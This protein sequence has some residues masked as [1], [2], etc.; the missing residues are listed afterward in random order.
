MIRF[1]FFLFVACATFNS[2]A[3][4]LGKSGDVT[5]LVKD[6]FGTRIPNAE[7]QFARLPSFKTDEEGKAIIQNVE[8]GRSYQIKVSAKDYR[9]YDGFHEIDKK[10]STITIELGWTVERWKE[11]TEQAR[12]EEIQSRDSI[13]AATDF[14]EYADCDDTTGLHYWMEAKFPGGQA[15]LNQY[16]DDMT[17]YPEPSIDMNEQGKVYLSFVVEMDG[18]ITG[19]KIERGVSS[20]IDREARRI[21]RSMPKWI[22]AYCNGEKV[23]VRCRVPIVFTLT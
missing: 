21:V 13:V 2:Q 20:D 5:I 11:Y 6:H 3:E 12:L 1:L 18:S 10:R 17:E 14:S 8:W 9:E 23:R 19:V 16:V 7:I 22:P 4:D 15:V